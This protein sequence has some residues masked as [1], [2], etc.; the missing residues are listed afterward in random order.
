MIDDEL[1]TDVLKING[2]KS[3]REAVELGLRTLLALK[4]QGK[5]IIQ[6]GALCGKAIWSRWEMSNDI[7]GLQY[8]AR[9]QAL[10]WECGLR[11]SSFPKHGKLELVASWRLGTNENTRFYALPAAKKQRNTIWTQIGYLPHYA[12][13]ILPRLHDYIKSNYE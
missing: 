11:S 5:N 2:I 7:G 8:F 10:A 1:I 9:S 3:K 6:K 12:L 13:G 4:Q